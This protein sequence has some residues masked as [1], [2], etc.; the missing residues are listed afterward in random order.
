MVQ[1]AA[2][3]AAEAEGAED[4]AEDETAVETPAIPPSRAEEAPGP[5][6]HVITA[7]NHIIQP[8]VG[9]NTHISHQLNG[10]N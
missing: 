2:E 3:H 8:H 7:V 1:H 9:S 6:H 5:L 4:A 10:G